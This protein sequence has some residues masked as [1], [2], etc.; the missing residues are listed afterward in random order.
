MGFS[1]VKHAAPGKK[2]KRERER[3]GTS[4]STYIAPQALSHTHRGL[5]R[6]EKVSAGR[7]DV[8]KGKTGKCQKSILLLIEMKEKVLDKSNNLAFFQLSSVAEC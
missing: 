2:S 4:S 5:D 8:R 6:G 1:H 7:E 3:E